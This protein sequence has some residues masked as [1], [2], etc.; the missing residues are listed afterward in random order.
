M[1]NS[2]EEVCRSSCG[3]RGED[4]CSFSISYA[5]GSSLFGIYLEDDIQ[6]ERDSAG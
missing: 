3:K 6:F 4:A 2:K 5:E 1:K